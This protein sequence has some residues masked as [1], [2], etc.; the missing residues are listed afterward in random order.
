M[1]V[2]CLYP[3]RDRLSHLFFSGLN[4]PQ[5]VDIS[6]INNGGYLKPL[7]GSV[8]YLNGG[9]FERDKDDNDTQIVLPD[10]CFKAIF[11]ELFE[12][13]N[14]T[15]TESTP[16]DV[17]VAVDPEMLGKVF[18]ELV[19]GRH[20]SGS[21]YTPKPIVSFMCREALKRY[22]KTQ[23][24]T[25]V[26]SC[27][28]LE[29]TAIQVRVGLPDV[30][31][32]FVD[33][34]DPSRLNNPE[35]VLEALRQVKICDPACGSG[36][37]LLGMLHELLDLRQCLFAT[38]KL[39]SESIYQRKLEIIENNLYGVDIDPFAINIARLRLWLSLA[40]EYEGDNPKPLPNLKY[41]IEQ[42]DSLIAPSPET[43]GMLRDDFI[44]KYR[45]AK[46]NYMRAHLKP[47]KQKFESEIESLKI[48]IALFTR[49]SSQVT[50]FDW[51]V[52]FAEVFSAGGFD[53]VTANPPYGASVDENVRQLYFDRRTEGAQSK[54]TYGLFMAR[55]LQLLRSGGQLCYIV[56]DTWQTIK[57][58]KPLRKR[59]VE[60]TEIAHLIDLPTWIF[61]ATV[62][63]C[64][65]TAAK[66]TPSKEHNLITADLRSLKTGDW[67]SLTKNLNA[68]GDR[69]VDLQPLN[70]ARYTYPQALIATY[71]NFSFFIASPTL[72]KLMSDKNLSR[73]GSIA[74]VKVGLQTGDNEY[75]LRKRAGVRGS[76][77]I[78]DESKLLTERDIAQLTEEEKRNGV[79]P[80]KYGGRCFLPYDKGGESDSDEGWLPNYY[81]PTQYFIDW[82][83]SA[84][85][86]L[87][88]ATIAD[89]K[90]RKGEVNKIKSRDNTKVASRFQ[91]SSCYFREGLTFSRTGQYAPTYRLSANSVFDTEGS[92]IFFNEMS[93]T[94]MLAL[95]TSTLA[96]YMVKCFVNHTVHAQVEDIKEF[97]IAHPDKE[98]V[99]EIELLVAKII[100]LQK[101]SP[102]YPYYL[103]EQKK[104]NK[105]IYKLYNLSNEDIREVEI[106]YCRRYPKLTEAQ[107]IL[108]EVHQKYADYLILCEQG[109]KQ[110]LNTLLSTQKNRADEQ[111]ATLKIY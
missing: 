109:L 56:S 51:A 25:E 16:L 35:A 64:I 85:Q 87:K 75:Y 1:H 4:S 20:E 5:E 68:I 89:V 70:Y 50:G 19:T 36:A 12:R 37:Y 93:A 38:K 43:I 62:N 111:V 52:E 92:S 81:V 6:N 39:G 34:H 33:E 26:A 96:R 86:R 28:A 30:I 53:I 46:V 57:S 72:Y 7:I 9:L 60:N 45:E 97:I 48:Q 106:W 13:F 82:S 23:V 98:T 17:E 27:V 99:K 94:I 103:Y 88:T 55:G 14:F 74:D 15:V 44:R 10:E 42:G 80:I 32:Q 67:Q 29:Q 102:R 91:N 95:L 65:F 104:L 90:R 79:E 8:P 101:V 18:E 47:E 100:V 21:Y 40:I 61:N 63:T 22:L 84:V 54:D 73:M 58:H 71:E 76:Y 83:K 77:R 24:S 66:N 11:T 3:Y 41:K 49:G 31:A 59:L 108:A 110:P 2:S 69:S 107:G 78:L 105:L